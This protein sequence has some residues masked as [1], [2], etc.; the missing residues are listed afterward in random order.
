MFSE[1]SFKVTSF[2]P[3]SWRFTS[4]AAAVNTLISILRRRRR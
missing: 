2:G 4:V 1:T 3:T